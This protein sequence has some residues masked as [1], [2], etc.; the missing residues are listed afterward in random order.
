MKKFETKNINDATPAEI[1][2]YA[3]TFLGIPTED[4][5]DAEVLA[6]T[7]A[8]NE[9]D[10]IFVAVESDED[11]GTQTG[12]PPPDV[13]NNGQPLAGGLGK[14]DPRVTLTLHAEERDGMVVN[15]H[16][17]I[18][19]GGVIWLLKRGESITIPYRVYEALNNAKRHAITHT[20]EGDVR[21]QIVHNTPFNIERMPSEEEIKAWHLRTDDQFAP[22]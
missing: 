3:Q 9:N 8:A 1:R 10:T 12:S 14:D 11:E 6:K 21:E 2:V 22:S 17:E 16:K 15:R 5:E 7:L 18:G 19:V 4:I 13:E 20:K